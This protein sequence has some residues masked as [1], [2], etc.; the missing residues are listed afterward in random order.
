MGHESLIMQQSDIAS[1]A[2]AIKDCLRCGKVQA[3]LHDARA[4]GANLL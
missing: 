2:D 4:R 1:I 3:C